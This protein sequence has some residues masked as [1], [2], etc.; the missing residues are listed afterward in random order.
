MS[1]LSWMG[2]RGGDNILETVVDRG[3]M[4]RGTV[5]G[6]SRKVIKTGQ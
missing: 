2:C 6:W 1:T 5:G 4:G 3:R